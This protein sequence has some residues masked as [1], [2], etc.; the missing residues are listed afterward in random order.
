[1]NRILIAAFLQLASATAVLAGPPADA[2][3]FFYRNL[4]AETDPANR[5][6]F[7]GKARVYLD[8]NDKAWEENEE[9]CLDFSVVVDGQDY[10]DAELARTLKL[11]EMT[12]ADGT[13]VIARFTLFGEPRAIEWTLVEEGGAWKVA[14]ITA[15]A[16]GW[17][18]SEFTCE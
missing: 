7:T 1:M 16:N 14:D 2:V 18:L 9:V 4:G 3:A 8:A 12:G 17:R 15:P 6:R 11:E 5:D 13:V 10:D